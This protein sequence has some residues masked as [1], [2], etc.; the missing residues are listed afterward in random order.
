MSPPE[1]QRHVRKGLLY[2]GSDTINIKL[3]GEARLRELGVKTDFDLRSKQQ[4]EKAGGY[5][6]MEG[7]ER[8]WA[9][10]FAEEQYTEEAA[11]QRYE[12]YAGEGTEVSMLRR[13]V[14]HGKR[15]MASHRV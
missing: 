8:I 11:R 6:E 10:V 12:L 15:L 14:N 5:R 4:I 1:V 13:E 7:I 9:P 3:E 2:R